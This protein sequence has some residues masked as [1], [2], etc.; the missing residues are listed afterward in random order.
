[1]Q[2]LLQRPLDLCEDGPWG[3]A[4]T[5]EEV[6]CLLCPHRLDFVRIG[7]LHGP[8]FPELPKSAAELTLLF[9]SLPS[10]PLQGAQ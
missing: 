6:R 4:S 2:S 9:G 8:G 5:K 1:M 10:A 7:R 3:D